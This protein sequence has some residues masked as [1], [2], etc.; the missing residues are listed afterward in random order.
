GPRPCHGDLGGLQGQWVGR[1]QR[2]KERRRVMKTWW[3]L[4]P[5][6]VVLVFCRSAHTAEKPETAATK[7]ALAWLAM[8]DQGKNGDG[9]DA[10]AKIF[11]GAVTRDKW[12]ES[13]TAARA[14]FG[15][16]VAR[17]LKSAKFTTTLPGAP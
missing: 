15:K 8:V 2:Q 14:P 11:K 10:A 7:E 6:L 9:W 5:V 17:K 16:V 13:V 4:V 3:S 1:C 12:I